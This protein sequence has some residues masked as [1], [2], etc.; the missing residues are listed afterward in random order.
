[1]RP[2]PLAIVLLLALAALLFHATPAAY[3]AC[4]TLQ[5]GVLTDS[6]GNPLRL[7]FDQWGYNYQAHIFN[8]LYENFSRPI[9]P[10]TESET[11][12]QMKW[13]DTWLSNKDCDGDGKL[14]RGLGTDTPGISQGWLTNHM[15]GSYLGLDGDTHNWTYFVKIVYMPSGCEPANVIWGLYCII[16]EVLNDPYAR[17]HGVNRSLLINPAGLGYWTN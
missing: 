17:L 4:T 9:P 2:L 14:D 1:M 11:A 16:E 6:Y 7:G 8:G 15:Q 10:A 12:L 5:S 3:A 13:S